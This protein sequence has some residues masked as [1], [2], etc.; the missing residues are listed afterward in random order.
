MAGIDPEKLGYWFDRF[1]RSFMLY[2]GQWVNRELAEDVVQDSFVKLAAQRREPEH[3]QA[4]LFRMVRHAAISRLR[5]RGRRA[6]REQRVAAENRSWFS[7]EAGARLDAELV[8]G[9]L[10]AL[11]M[12]LREAV[13]LRIW[14]GLTFREMGQV[15][16]VSTASAYGR[17]QAAI[18]ALMERMGEPCRKDLTGT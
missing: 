11:P 1:G 6:K 8:Q 3:V 4:Y 16:G 12:E 7:E 18:A 15:L 9:E 2:A 13:V 17:Y 5:S 14:A 10:E